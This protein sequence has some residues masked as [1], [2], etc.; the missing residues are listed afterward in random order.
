MVVEVLCQNRCRRRSHTV[1][2]VTAFL[3]APASFRITSDQTFVSI[4]IAASFA[5]TA[6][7][8]WP[9][10]RKNS[11]PECLQVCRQLGCRG[12]C[13]AEGV[14]PADGGYAATPRLRRPARPTAAKMKTPRR[15]L[16]TSRGVHNAARAG[17]GPLGLPRQSKLWRLTYGTPP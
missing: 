6:P 8:P 9:P 11:T 3:D 16:P 2:N 4:F 13:G 15:G 14:G 17:W 12:R 10:R 5:D 1:E 7:R